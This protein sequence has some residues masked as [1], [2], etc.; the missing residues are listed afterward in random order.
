[1]QDLGQNYQDA[2]FFMIKMRVQYLCI[3]NLCIVQDDL[4]DWR[5]E[6]EAMARI[7]GGALF[8][9]ARQCDE[10]SSI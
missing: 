5:I 10:F 6:S 3:D 7:Y 2:V 8:T 1:I 4:E 9:I